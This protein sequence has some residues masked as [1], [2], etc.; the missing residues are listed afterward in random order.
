MDWYICNASCV[1]DDRA[2]GRSIS[3]ELMTAGRRY[4]AG[5]DGV[6]GGRGINNNNNNYY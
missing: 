3:L 6:G 5:N 2:K 4:E 1:V